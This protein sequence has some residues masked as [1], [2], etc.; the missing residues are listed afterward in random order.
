M[1]S[2]S[3]LRPSRIAVGTLKQWLASTIRRTCGPIALRTAATRSMSRSME[4][5]PIFILI[6]LK[7]AST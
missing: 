5:S 4:P 1:P 2:S 6:A 3:S 7:P